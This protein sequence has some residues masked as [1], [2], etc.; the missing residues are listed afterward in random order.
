MAFAKRR[1]AVVR[2]SH[3]FATLYAEVQEINAKG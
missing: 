1:I 2:V 3:L